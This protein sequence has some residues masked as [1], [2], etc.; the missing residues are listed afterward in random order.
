MP[1][2]GKKQEFGCW[3]RILFSRTM[4]AVVVHDKSPCVC[5]CVSMPKCMFGVWVFLKM[6]KTQH[7][8]VTFQTSHSSLMQRWKYDEHLHKCVTLRQFIAL[9][10]T[11]V[12]FAHAKLPVPM[13]EHSGW[14][15][16]SNSNSDASLWCFTGEFVH[17]DARTSCRPV[18]IFNCPSKT[19]TSLSTP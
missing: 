19:D 13:P 18:Q 2:E 8:S 9:K 7:K 3:N 4:K 14:L 11:Q 1:F 5:V 10:E 6:Q 16:N 15:Q 12:A 17:V